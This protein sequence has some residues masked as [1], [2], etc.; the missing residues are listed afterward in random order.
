MGIKGKHR[1]SLRHRHNPDGIRP[2]SD[3]LPKEGHSVGVYF[4]NHLNII[5][6]RITTAVLSQEN[7]ASIFLLTLNKLFYVPK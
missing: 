3:C 2:A 4:W 1:V 5:Y 7:G 6:P